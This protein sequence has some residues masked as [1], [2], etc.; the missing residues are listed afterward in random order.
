MQDSDGPKVAQEVYRALFTNTYRHPVS[1][2]E[3]EE[4]LDSDVIPYALDDAVTSLRKA[5]ALP[6]TWATFIHIGL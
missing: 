2:D 6:S 1:E 5:G 4:V 3:T